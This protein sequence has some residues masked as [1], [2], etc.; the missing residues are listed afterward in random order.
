MGRP[1]SVDQVVAL[2]QERGD[3]RSVDALRVYVN[4][5]IND[6]DLA[7]YKVNPGRLTSPWQMTTEDVQGWLDADQEEDAKTR[8]EGE[9][10]SKE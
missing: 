7:G 1:M 8:K 5:A 9:P 6:G 3:T 10:C 2:L 4:R